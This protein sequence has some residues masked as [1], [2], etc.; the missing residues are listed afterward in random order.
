MISKFKKKVV[1]I[2]NV[3]PS[4]RKDFFERLNHNNNFDIKIYASEKNELGLKS[5]DLPGVDVDYTLKL[6]SIGSKLMFQSFIRPLIGLNK[7]D[8]LVISGNPRI[9]TNY[10]LIALARLKGARVVC[11]SHGW[12][13]GSHGLTSKIRIKMMSMY[14]AVLLYTD[15]EV[16]QFKRKNLISKPTFYL[17]N[18]LDYERITEVK[19]SVIKSRESKGSLLKLVFCG[20][21]T[22]KSK[23]DLLLVAAH[24]LDEVVQLDIIGS[25]EFYSFCVR[26]IED[27]NLS[28]VTLHGQ[29][30]DETQLA[31]IYTNS[32]VFV[33]PGKVGLSLIHAFCYGLPAILHNK[34]ELQMPEFAASNHRN[35]VYFDYDN[36]DSL[37]SSILYFSKLPPEQV[38]GM[39]NHSDY[40]AREVYNV[41]MM[42]ENFAFMVDKI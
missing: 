22:E 35:T 6:F 33:Y 23:I 29:V 1:I 7:N 42:C 10:I 17:N 13:A 24:R 20:R 41:R 18:G 16:E 19:N 32:D 15:N 39:K 30:F 28:N 34:P 40:I 37:V 38:D 4:Y 14:N 9:L 3:L 21:L 5:V 26:Y 36:V 11:W 27:H 2:Q 8:I 25:G 31:Q 12:T